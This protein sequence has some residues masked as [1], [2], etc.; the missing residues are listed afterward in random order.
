[1]PVVYSRS[2]PVVCPSPFFLLV[3]MHNSRIEDRHGHWMC[4]ISTGGENMLDVRKTC[5]TPPSTLSTTT[6][7]SVR[8]D[9]CHLESYERPLWSVVT[10]VIIPRHRDTTFYLGV[11]LRLHFRFWRPLPHSICGRIRIS[12]GIGSGRILGLLMK[13]GRKDDLM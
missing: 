4:L 5:N 12:L 2:V 9:S 11:N 8:A 1:M 7:V 3:D 10:A 13:Q 6:A